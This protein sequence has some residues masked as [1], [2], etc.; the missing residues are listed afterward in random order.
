MN[1]GRA[2]ADVVAEPAG[3]Y[4][5]F[6]MRNAFLI[7][8]I[9]A[10]MIADGGANAAAA[11]VDAAAPSG[12]DRS[13]VPDLA[14][15][16]VTFMPTGLGDDRIKSID[17]LARAIGY[18]AA[19]EPQSGRMAV[20]QVILNRVRH[21]AFPKTVCGVVYQGS[22]RRTGCQFTFTCDGSL[23]RALSRRTWAD[24]LSIAGQAMDG[25][26]PATVG[27]A[28]HY[29]A[30]YVSPR[31]APAM[32]RVGQIGAHIF[33]HFPGAVA[34]GEMRVALAADKS[35]SNT[36]RRPQPYVFSA[37]GLAATVSS[38]AE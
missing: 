37:W 17:C 21:R 34:D 27:T 24:A 12:V 3:N 20:A 7:T 35:G 10:V 33:Y 4:K 28:T 1:N 23:R 25:V 31:W 22:Q 32:V 8:A 6:F 11:S 2:G 26:L 18:E 36:A 29:H 14:G 30:S 16:S 5:H 19:N 9:T 13:G 38:G 15:E